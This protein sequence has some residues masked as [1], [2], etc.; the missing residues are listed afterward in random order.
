MAIDVKTLALANLVLQILLVIT[1]LGAA[2]LAKKKK[3]ALHC[4][5]MRTLVPVQIIAIAAVM[6][7][8]MLGYIENGYPSAF[9]KT[10]MFV[11]H[12]FGILVIVLWIYINLSFGKPWMPRNLRPFMRLAFTLWML[13]LLLGMHM[14]IQ[15]YT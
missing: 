12:A 8:S 6:L 1:V 3:L 10:E 13:A 5:F 11:H 2:Y 9:F 15:I 14:Y 4:K 7:P